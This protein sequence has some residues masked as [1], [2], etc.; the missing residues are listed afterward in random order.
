MPQLEW[1][2]YLLLCCSSK[3]D[4]PSFSV[5]YTCVS[6]PFSWTSAIWIK[7]PRSTK[8][9][10]LIPHD[11]RAIG[12]SMTGYNHP[13]LMIWNAKIL[14]VVFHNKSFF[15]GSDTVN[16]NQ[17]HAEICN[18][19]FHVAF[20]WNVNWIILLW[21]ICYI[22]VN[23]FHMLK[24]SVQECLAL[25]VYKRTKQLCKLIEAERNWIKKALGPVQ[26][27]QL[28]LPNESWGS[29]Q[30]IKYKDYIHW[31][32]QLRKKS[33]LVELNVRGLFPFLFFSIFLKLC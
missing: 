8:I 30:K 22:H 11:F 3:H 14:E 31:M 1:R 26:I 5:W 29:I 16:K 20:R 25:P 18:L 15:S 28:H 7:S 6:V 13:C 21:H 4:A 24:R 27:I 19:K 23:M 32:L 9:A 10:L 33:H 17:I 12:R 2:T